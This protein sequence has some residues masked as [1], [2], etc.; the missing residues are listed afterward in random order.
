MAAVIEIRQAYRLLAV[1]VGGC[2]ANLKITIVSSRTF[3]VIC[4][5]KA[6]KVALALV[7]VWKMAIVEAVW[8][9]ANPSEDSMAAV[10]RRQGC[11]AVIC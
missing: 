1:V 3:F 4:F 2:V 10:I 11:L 8:F 5:V 6:H 9:L 7:A